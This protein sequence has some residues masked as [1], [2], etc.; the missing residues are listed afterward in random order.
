MFAPKRE[1]DGLLKTLADLEERIKRQERVA[2]NL[3]S[4]HDYCHE[5]GERLSTFT[6]EEKRLALEA[7]GVE[8]TANGRCWRMDTL[9]PEYL[10]PKTISSN[11][12]QN[13]YRV[14]LAYHP[15]DRPARR[16]SVS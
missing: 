5:V 9:I 8:I 16:A 11:C 6:F 2:I 7:L 15:P 13:T 14:T 3:K 1:R 10:E 4:L 12:L